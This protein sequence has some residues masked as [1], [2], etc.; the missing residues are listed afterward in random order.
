MIG[1]RSGAGAASGAAER[2]AAAAE[3]GRL[4]PGPV[5][6]APAAPAARRADL[7][8]WPRGARALSPL[9]MVQTKRAR[10]RRPGDAGEWQESK[11]DCDLSMLWSRGFLV[12]NIVCIIMQIHIHISRNEIILIAFKKTDSVKK[13]CCDEIYTAFTKRHVNIYCFH[14]FKSVYSSLSLCTFLLLRIGKL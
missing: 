12:F 10:Y 4:V 8:A 5:P 13:Q 14:H 1:S 6:A 9:P 2:R 3:A 11:S 7:S